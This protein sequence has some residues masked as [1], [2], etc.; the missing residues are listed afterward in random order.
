MNHLRNF[1]VVVGVRSEE[2][3]DQMLSNALGNS[4]KEEEKEQKAKEEKVKK[5]EEE[6]EG[7]RKK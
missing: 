7:S 2:T 6:K 1:S 4:V 3:R 5:E